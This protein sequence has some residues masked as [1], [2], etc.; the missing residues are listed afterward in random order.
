MRGCQL[1]ASVS[2]VTDQALAELVLACPQLLPGSI[3]GCDHAKGD[4]FVQ[5]VAKT[6]PNLEQLDLRKSAGVT[7]AS[8][9]MLVEGC[10]QLHPN[11]LLCTKK[12]DRYL[13]AIAKAFPNLDEIDLEGCSA[14]TSA[15]LYL[16]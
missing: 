12:G 8:L 15:G 11:R 10:P 3:E 9:A 5:A 14:V 13:S 16:L 6:H 1:S 7:D 2:Q 4:A